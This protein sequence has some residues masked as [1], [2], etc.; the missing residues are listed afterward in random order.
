MILREID[1]ANPF[2]GMNPYLE[3]ADYWRDLHSRLINAISDLLQPALRP[4]YNARIEERLL[5]VPLSQHIYP[6][7]SISKNTLREAATFYEVDSPPVAYDDK[8]ITPPLLV[9]VG[10]VPPETYIEIVRVDTR[11]VVTAIEVLSPTNK[12]KGD[13]LEAYARKRRSVLSSQTNLVEIDL[14]R[15]GVR[16]IPQ[17]AECDVSRCRY[18]IGVNRATKREQFELYPVALNETLPKFNIPLREPDPDVP[19]DLQAAFERC[20]EGGAYD[21][22]VDYNQP[23]S[24]VMTELEREWMNQ[25]LSAQRQPKEQAHPN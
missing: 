17:P 23:P 12:A 1:M 4:C 16:L 21:D 14:L 3:S 25:S 18:M 15:E 8:A 10:G 19:L 5:V 6:D 7:V 11:E 24:A 2:P 9:S 22:L 13:G 20:Y